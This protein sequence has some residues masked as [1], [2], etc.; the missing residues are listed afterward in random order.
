MELVGV[1]FGFGVGIYLLTAMLLV[2]LGQP[3]RPVANLL[4]A[5]TFWFLVTVI[6]LAVTL[7]WV[8]YMG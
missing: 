2:S 1:G 6:C 3:W 5:T 8:R 7:A 4:K